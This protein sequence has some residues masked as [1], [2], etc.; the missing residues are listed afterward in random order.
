MFS[1]KIKILM[2]LTSNSIY[3]KKRKKNLLIMKPRPNCTTLSA[4]E[5]YSERLRS[6]IQ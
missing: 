5:H 3:L 1:N 4:L 2:I 6:F